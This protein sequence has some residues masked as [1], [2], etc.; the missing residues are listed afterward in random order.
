MC[1]F[2][3]AVSRASGH[4]RSAFWTDAI[5]FGLDVHATPDATP[6]LPWTLPNFDADLASFLLARGPFSW[7]GY[8]WMG[9]GCGWGLQV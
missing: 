1:F 9:C 2:L 4:N 3:T 6:K 7:L 8:Q 5:Y